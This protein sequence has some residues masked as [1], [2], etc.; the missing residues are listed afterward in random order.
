MI[1][2]PNYQL[3]KHNLML[4]QATHGVQDPTTGEIALMF[5]AVFILVVILLWRKFSP[6]RW[7]SG[8][9]SDEIKKAWFLLAT[10][11]Q[12]IAFTKLIMEAAKSD[13]KITGDENEAIFEEITWDHKNAAQTMSTEDMFSILSA[14]SPE[15]RAKV[16]RAM[17]TLLNS[18]GEFAAAEAQWLAEVTER[19]S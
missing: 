13:G 11:D 15:L 3:K 19:L 5:T 18:D 2:T 7:R 6:R 17:Q 16:I 14:L 10:G 1:E 12:K 9:V 8:L 4:L